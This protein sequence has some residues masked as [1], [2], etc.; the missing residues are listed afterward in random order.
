MIR[1]MTGFGR[2]IIEED[3]RRISIE[4]KSVNHRYLDISIRMP[5]HISF[6]E[7]SLRQRLGSRLS[8]GHV[9][10]YVSYG[11]TRS[12]ARTVSIDMPLVSAYIAAAKEA[13]AALS[14]IDDITLSKALRLPDVTVVTEADEDR[15]AVLK[16]A[17][18][19]LDIALD[20]LIAAR[21]AEGLRLYDSFEQLTA[22]IDS[23]LNQIKERAPFIV[24]EYAAKLKERIEF[25]LKDTIVDE[26]RLAAEVAIFADKCCIDEEIV[27]IMSHIHDIRQLFWCDEAVG[28]KLDFVIQEL[29]RE[30]NT[31]GSKANDIVITKCVLAAKAEIEKM[32]EQIQNIE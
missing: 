15:D 22:S 23:I 9:D 29:N 20:E 31:I 6:I 7:D 28:R 18:G 26:S 19:A 30:F 12:D 8:R 3:G 24:T 27:R 21:S 17:L 4:L 16:I 13:G 10:I 32:R 11:N 1:S 14:L 5:R 25:L 2:G